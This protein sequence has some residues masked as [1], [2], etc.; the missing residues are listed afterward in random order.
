MARVVERCISEH[1][2]ERIVS[3]TCDW[4]E[5]PVL[6]SPDEHGPGDTRAFTIICTT[7]YSY[8]GDGC[9]QE[10]EMQDLC[11]TCTAILRALLEQSGIRIV[12]VDRE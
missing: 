6:I 8:P 4:C 9:T 1:T 5:A 12:E 11:D 10:G 2:C 3:R 7:G